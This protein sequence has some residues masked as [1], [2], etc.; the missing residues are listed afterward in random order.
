MERLIKIRDLQRSDERIVR[1]L[2]LKGSM[3]DL[4]QAY[5]NQLLQCKTFILGYV[6]L[7]AVLS[8]CLLS[9]VTSAIISFAVL[10]LLLY[11][12]GP[13]LVYAYFVVFVFKAAPTDLHYGL[14]KFWI[15]QDIPSMRM[16]VLTVDDEIAGI[17]AIR[18]ITVEMTVDKFKR[19]ECVPD[20]SDAEFERLV[21]DKRF[22]GLGLSNKLIEH[23]LEFAKSWKYERVHLVT[24]TLYCGFVNNVYRK[25]GWKEVNRTPVFQSVLTQHESEVE[26]VLNLN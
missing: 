2:A 11:F 12:S 9:P 22:R 3:L 6:T 26:Y 24:S 15:R 16:F 21:V 14:C 17:A 18:P 10:P 1:R 5:T 8:T 25:Y 13:Y 4:S 23:A 7:F 20:T 19:S